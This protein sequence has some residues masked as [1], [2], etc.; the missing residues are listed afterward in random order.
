MAGL[1]WRGVRIAV[2]TLGLAGGPLDGAAIVVADPANPT[3]EQVLGG[4]VCE[5][6]PPGMQYTATYFQPCNSAQRY[7]FGRS[8]N[9]QNLVCSGG[10]PN[11]PIWGQAP[12]LFGVQA[13]GAACPSWHPGGAAAQTSDGRALICQRGVGW[14]VNS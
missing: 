8:S 2:A 7:I 11:G 13:P 5:Q 10:G 14:T 3:C 1:K 9:G 4:T 12:P 6:D